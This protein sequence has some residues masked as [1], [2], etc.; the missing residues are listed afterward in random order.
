MKRKYLTKKDAP[1]E[2]FTPDR[3]EKDLKKSM[4]LRPKPPIEV[5]G[6]MSVPFSF[7]LEPPFY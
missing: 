2:W 4:P 5:D 6:V 1:V 3:I 7:F